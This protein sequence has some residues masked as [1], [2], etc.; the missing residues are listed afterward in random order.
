[1]TGSPIYDHHAHEEYLD[2]MDLMTALHCEE[3]GELS[4]Q[5]IVCSCGKV[6]C[7]GCRRLC[8]DCDQQFCSNCLT[9]VGTNDKG[10]LEFRCTG[11]LRA[12]TQAEL[13]SAIE[14]L[15]DTISAEQARD[16]YFV[17]SVRLMSVIEGRK[18]K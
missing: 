12:A 8:T 16:F 2:A 1:M 11:C 13:I 5:T 14:A 9:R 15:P 7:D 18:A 6:T 3:C 4:P 10:K 17:L